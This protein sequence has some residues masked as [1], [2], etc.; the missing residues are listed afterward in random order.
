MAI[1]KEVNIVNSKLTFKLSPS[2]LNLMH[3]CLDAF[4]FL[5]IKSGQDLMGYF[6]VC[7]VGRMGY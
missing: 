2:T 7:P 1:Q 4:G 5:R 6:Q 3:E